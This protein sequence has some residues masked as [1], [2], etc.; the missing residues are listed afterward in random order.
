MN[1]LQ[2][3]KTNEFIDGNT[4]TDECNCYTAAVAAALSL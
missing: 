1:S 3:K 4:G 2:N